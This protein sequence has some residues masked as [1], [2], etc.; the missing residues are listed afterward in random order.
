LDESCIAGFNRT[1]E[2]VIS[3]P[4]TPT[5]HEP[6]FSCLVVTGLVV[7]DCISNPAQDR[8]NFQFPVFGF[9]Y[10]Q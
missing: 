4:A 10:T 2:S 6:P 1:T 9:T 5:V 7:Y 3:F 8:S